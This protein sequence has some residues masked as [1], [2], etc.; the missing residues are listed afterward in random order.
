MYIWIANGS[1]ACEKFPLRWRRRQWKTSSLDS[2]MGSC[3]SSALQPSFLPLGHLGVMNHFFSG[4]E[5]ERLICSAVCD[6]HRFAHQAEDFIP[7]L[8]SD[9]VYLLVGSS[10]SAWCC[11]RSPW[12]L[13][14]SAPSPPLPI[15]QQALSKAESWE[16]FK[17]VIFHPLATLF[18]MQFRWHVWKK[19]LSSLMEH[20]GHLRGKRSSPPQFF[21]PSS[22]Q[23]SS[24]QPCLCPGSI[25]HVV[26]QRCHLLVLHLCNAAFHLS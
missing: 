13:T 20:N 17:L 25:I 5:F 3:T 16:M 8:A 1:R 21:H 23:D 18:C 9:N 22:L 24:F 6:R 10:V 26:Q 2:R 15:C 19:S 14:P 4:K 7:A 11:G 12:D